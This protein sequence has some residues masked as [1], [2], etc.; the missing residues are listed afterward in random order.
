[1][2][3]LYVLALLL[4]SF[5]PSYGTD[6]GPDI[7]M[8]MN[9]KAAEFMCLSQRGLIENSLAA[10]SIPNFSSGSNL[11]V[12]V[13]NIVK[14]QTKNVVIVQI[15]VDFIPQT[16]GKFTFGA[17]LT[18]EAITSL[19]TLE[20]KITA[21][22][23]AEVETS[24]SAKGSPF[25]TVTACMPV[26]GPL[27]LLSPG[28][29]SISLDLVENHLHSIFSGQLCSTISQFFDKMD[30]ML[31]SF[32][33]PTAFGS[34]AQ[35]QYALTRAPELTIENALLSLN[36]TISIFGKIMDL[37]LDPVSISL[38]APSSSASP[39][40]EL[41]LTENVFVELYAALQK[42][43]HLD[44]EITGQTIGDMNRLTTATLSVAIPQINELYPVSAAIILKNVVASPP[45]VTLEAD[46]LTMLLNSSIDI[47]VKPLNVDAKSLLVLKVDIPLSITLKVVHGKLFSTANLI[48]DFSL[49]VQTSAV[50]AVDVSALQSL[51]GNTLKYAYLQLLN[52]ALGVGLTL[53]NLLNVDLTDP[54]ITIYQ[55]FVLL[56]F[57]LQ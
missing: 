56:C 36:I 52:E 48:R 7:L 41:A 32:S 51:V 1:M 17:D 25:G 43:E 42:L 13:L 10:I 22:I 54:T 9:E 46:K 20:L 4:G 57:V 6:V 33:A 24:K 40:L 8:R 55:G 53:P 31:E 50:G 30:G 23:M 14:I 16:K 21:Q 35:I 45:V 28:A 34:M 37:H 38:P 11:S 47:I 49:R 19:T 12:N 44:F 5:S 3:K 2:V 39:S 18:L 26:L 15:S 27:Q 29:L